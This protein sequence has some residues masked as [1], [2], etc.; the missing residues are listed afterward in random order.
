MRNILAFLA[1]FAAFG[2]VD[3]LM[4]NTAFV[5]QPGPP[6][7]AL[8]T[9]YQWQQMLPRGH[10]A[11]EQDWVPGKWPMGIPAQVA[12][13]GN[14]WMVGR[15]HSWSS[16]D[17]L[18]WTGYPKKDWGERI[19]ISYFFFDNKLWAAGGMLYDQ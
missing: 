11:Y 4:T 18:N 3:R 17:G 6:P 5:P 9:H 13:D 1:V 19:S 14:L 12:I 2:S 15:K 10:G 16:S 7:P 8:P